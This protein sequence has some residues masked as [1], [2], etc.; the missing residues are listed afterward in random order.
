MNP[1]QRNDD[2]QID[3][4]AFG[5]PALEAEW[6]AQEQALRAERGHADGAHDDARLRSYRAITR[7]LREPLADALPADFAARMARRVESQAE[8]SP[9][10]TTRFERIA[11]GTMIALFGIAIGIAVAMSA[12]TVL[13]PV[14]DAV[15][16]I[17]GWVANPWL[18]ALGACL[19]VSSAVQR[20]T[21]ALSAH[22]A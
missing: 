20:W 8:D 6:Q 14:G 4:R 10:V 2:P 17:V 15:R 9:A 13:Q 18:V 7:A 12:S 1:S 19:A 11:I 21:R 22:A 3:D 16:Q 5:D